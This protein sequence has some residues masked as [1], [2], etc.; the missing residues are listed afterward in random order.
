MDLAT[1][2][3]LS[4]QIG[5]PQPLT[6]SRKPIDDNF[7]VFVFLAILIAILCIIAVIYLKDKLNQTHAEISCLESTGQ[8]LKQRQEGSLFSATYENELKSFLPLQNQAEEKLDKTEVLFV[9]NRKYTIT[10]YHHEERESSSFEKS[11]SNN[12]EAFQNVPNS[13]KDTLIVNDETDFSDCLNK[14]DFLNVL[15]QE[16]HHFY[17]LMQLFMDTIADFCEVAEDCDFSGDIASLD[18]FNHGVEHINLL[19]DLVNSN[20]KYFSED[21]QLFGGDFQIGA[22]GGNTIEEIRDFNDNVTLLNER[23]NIYNN[24]VLHLQYIAKNYNDKYQKV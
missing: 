2:L 16:L 24:H 7:A 12:F 3:K 4:V 17:I 18:D 9:N 22:Y 5:E 19:S 20:F 13:V 1:A 8:K 6:L 11:E 14:S 10:T 23:V 15:N 21:V